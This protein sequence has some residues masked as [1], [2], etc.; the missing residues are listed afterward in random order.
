MDTEPGASRQERSVDWLESH[1]DLPH[2]FARLAELV[3]LSGYAPEDLVIM[4]RTEV[5]RRETA[6]FTA[7]W[8]EAVSDELPRIRREYEKR[9]ADAYAQGQGDARGIRRP[10][11]RTDPNPDGA[12]VIT[13]PFARLMEPPASL[14]EAEERVR[15]ERRLF[16]QQAEHTYAE[17]PGPGTDPEPGP[18]RDPG[19]GRERGAGAGAEHGAEEDPE[20]E[21]TLGAE[22]APDTEA[23]S[24]GEA[25][26]EDM[27]DAGADTGAGSESESEA[28]AGPAARQRR[29]LRAA[30]PVRK[31][32]RGKGGRP[33]V[34]PL[35][36]VPGQDRRGGE[37][38]APDGRPRARGRRLS[39]RARALEQELGAEGAQEAPPEP[40]P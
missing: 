21:A 23:V 19:P 20:T 25:E 31:V 29:P 30:Q 4:P 38:G 5:D 32:V 26:A 13:L 7:G 36:S 34:P 8:A 17:Q 27:S 9:V 35:T 6:A 18:V 28:A 14:V 39:D 12:R 15:L 10:E 33:I 16:D 11:R 37:P 3:H 2:L 1:P 22:D 40:A 24:E